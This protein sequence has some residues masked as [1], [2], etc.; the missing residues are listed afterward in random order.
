MKAT[1][2]IVTLG[3]ILVA[4]VVVAVILTTNI[5]GRMSVWGILALVFGGLATL[6][7]AGGLMALVFYSARRGYDDIER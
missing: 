5:G 1:L 2:L 4:T 3:T 6:G 7:L